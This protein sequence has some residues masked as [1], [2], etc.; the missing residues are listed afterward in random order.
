MRKLATAALVAGLIAIPA[1]PAAASGGCGWPVCGFINHVHD[2]GYNPDIT[3]ECDNNARTWH[4]LGEHES[5]Q[6][7]GC[8]DVRRVHVP[9][10]AEI[11]CDGTWPT[12][13][14]IFDARGWHT[15]PDNPY[16]CTVRRD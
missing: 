5:S 1:S 7:H 11:V 2:N 4:D 6:D 13:D 14:R 9:V 8:R 3:I 12:N 15:F 10:D 16:R